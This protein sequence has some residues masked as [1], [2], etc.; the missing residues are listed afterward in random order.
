MYTRNLCLLTAL[1]IAISA[2]TKLSIEEA[3]AASDATPTNYQFST[4]PSNIAPT[5]ATAPYNNIVVF[6]QPRVS[7]THPNTLWDQEDINHYKE[8]LKTSKELQLQFAE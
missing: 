3:L 4:A 6:G 1:L 5:V 7:K 2:S 8:M